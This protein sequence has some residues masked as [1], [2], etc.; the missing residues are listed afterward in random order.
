M[1]AFLQKKIWFPD[2]RH[3][4]QYLHDGLLAVGGDMSVARLQL[5]YRMGIFPWTD[6]PVT[7]WS[8]DPRGIFDLQR[9]RIGRSLTKILRRGVFTCT[10]NKAFPQVIRACAEAPRPGGWITDQFI[11]GYLKLHAAGCAHSVECWQG[12]ALVG[13]VYGVGIQ[14]LF[15]GESMFYRASNASKVALVFLMEHLRQRGYKLFD[16]QMLTPITESMGA[17]HVSRNAYLDRLDEAL[18]HACT[19]STHEAEL[20]GGRRTS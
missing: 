7:W 17:F 2:P 9:I 20:P 15:A 18:K 12:D 11:R 10:I 19:F 6:R 3:Y 14:G 13:G 4:D 5:A 16:I 1:V 8:P